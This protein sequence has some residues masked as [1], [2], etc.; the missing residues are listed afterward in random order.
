MTKPSAYLWVAA[1]F[2]VMYGTSFLSDVLNKDPSVNYVTMAQVH[3]RQDEVQNRF[4]AY[5]TAIS[6]ARKSGIDPKTVPL[7]V[8][9]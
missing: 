7:P 2:A 6:N 8:K 1:G 4:F 5:T 3:T 9:D